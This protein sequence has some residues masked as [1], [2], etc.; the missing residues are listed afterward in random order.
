VHNVALYIGACLMPA[1]QGLRIVPEAHADFFQQ[2]VGLS[3]NAAESLF[4]HKIEVGEP[5]GEAWGRN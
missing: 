2:P 3:F 1:T 5:A 4:V